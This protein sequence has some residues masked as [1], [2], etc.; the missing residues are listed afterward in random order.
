LLFAVER[1]EVHRQY[2]LTAI[3]TIKL[4]NKMVRNLPWQRRH[5]PRLIN[6]P[7]LL[8]LTPITFRPALLQLS[9]TESTPPPSE[10]NKIC[11]FSC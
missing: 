10:I 9:E 7:F 8:K 5:D 2:Y 11:E 4:V 3:K 6:S 1:F